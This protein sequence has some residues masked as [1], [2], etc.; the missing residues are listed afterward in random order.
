MQCQQWCRTIPQQQC[1]THC[2]RYCR[3]RPETH[4]PHNTR[5]TVAFPHILSSTTLPISNHWT[6]LCQLQL[7]L[8]LMF[9]LLLPSVPPTVEAVRGRIV[10]LELMNVTLAFVIL[11][12][13]P[14]VLPGNIQWT[15]MDMQGTRFSIPTNSLTTSFS[16]LTGVFSDD[17]LNLTLLGL[18][19]DFE[20]T[21]SMTAT[22]EAG[23]NSASVVLLTEGQFK[24]ALK[25][26][27]NDSEPLPSPQVV[28]ESSDHQRA[29][30]W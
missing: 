14:E 11:D 21:Y 1:S 7:S 20:G 27:V 28:L 29:N 5:C 8:H 13:S 26:I 23:S 30:K 4:A 25:M 12:A 16:N 18:M 10:G 24:K 19:F 9:L 2:T 22:N 15:F 6:T 17:Q 3:P